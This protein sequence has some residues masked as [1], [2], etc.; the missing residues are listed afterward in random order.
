M[1]KQAFIYNHARF[2]NRTLGTKPAA[3]YLRNQGVGLEQALRVLGVWRKETCAPLPERRGWQTV[4]YPAGYVQG[5]WSFGSGRGV[6]DMELGDAG[7]V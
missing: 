2:I 7:G 3:G 5:S 6:V 1:S 4:H